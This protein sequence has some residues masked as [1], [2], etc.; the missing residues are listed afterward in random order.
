MTINIQ[1]ATPEQLVAIIK[2]HFNIDYTYQDCL[3]IVESITLRKSRGILTP[4]NKALIA[5]L[6]APCPPPI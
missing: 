6:E 2:G 5:K 3:D 1:A 4:N